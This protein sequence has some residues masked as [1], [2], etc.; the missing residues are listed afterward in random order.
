MS[1][2]IFY[3]NIQHIIYLYVE[4]AVGVSSLGL[5]P[6]ILACVPIGL[7]F[8][9]DLLQLFTYFEHLIICLL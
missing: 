7:S 4:A 2:N 3:L 9:T 1:F 5:S 8:I 6:R